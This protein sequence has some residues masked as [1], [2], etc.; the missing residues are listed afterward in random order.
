[1]LL[2]QNRL[3]F[4]SVACVKIRVFSLPDFIIYNAY[5]TPQKRALMY[6]GM[7]YVCD[8]QNMNNRVIVKYPAKSW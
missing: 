8:I 6:D 1:M 5:V 3:A 7:A 2:N 4:V